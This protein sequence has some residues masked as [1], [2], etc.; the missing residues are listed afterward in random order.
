MS[1]ILPSS[2]LLSTIG[3][4]DIPVL[5]QH[6]ISEPST[7]ALPPI[8]T[9]LQAARQSCYVYSEADQLVFLQWWRTTHWYFTNTARKPD[10]R[11]RIIWDSTLNRAGF[12]EY[13]SLAAQKSN[14]EPKLICRRCDK[15][16]A[17]PSNRAQKPDGSISSRQGN[18]TP[19]EHLVSQSCK[20]KSTKAG[21]T[22]LMIT[23]LVDR[24]MKVYTIPSL[25]YILN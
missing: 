18:K 9:L 23:D 16:L 19:K 2:P 5:Q 1:E 11:V 8:S 15:A 6:T 3:F 4:T 20:A 12:W 13:Y 7:A 21:L 22:Q 25:R 14:G 17:H 10:D 24:K